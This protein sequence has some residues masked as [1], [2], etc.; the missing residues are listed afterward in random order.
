MP[1]PFGP[2]PRRRCGCYKARALHNVTCG[3]KDPRNLEG[4]RYRTNDDPLD[5]ARGILLG[6][7]LGLVVWL[8]VV[9]PAIYFLSR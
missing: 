3:R 6:V 7:F 9:L 4:T 1:G 2:N 5:P 8:G